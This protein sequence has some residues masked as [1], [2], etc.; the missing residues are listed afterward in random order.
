[1]TPKTERFEMRLDPATVERIDAWRENHGDRPSRAEAIRRL[2][3]IGM[4][5]PDQRLPILPTNPEKLMLWMLAEI[6]RLQPAF[7]DQ[8]TT[9]LI[10]SAIYGGHFWA[11]DWELSGIL[12]HHAD[13]KAAL[14]LVID[15]MDMWEFIERAF[16]TFSSEQRAR[17][18]REVGPIGKNPRFLGFDGNNEGEYLGIAKFL[19]EELGRFESFKGRD[20][21]S[22]MPTTARYRL[23]TQRFE[24]IR[25][26]L[27][28]RELTADET[29]E[30]LA[31]E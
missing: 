2:I 8:K 21:N 13:S 6:L 14:R 24:P 29:I 5:Q 17:I 27:I 31:R 16:A 30:I 22:Y 15:T 4:G 20:L 10:Q 23:M 11:L 7:E 19:I 12:H 26:R 9:S 28:G 1:M 25:T 18:E 3:E